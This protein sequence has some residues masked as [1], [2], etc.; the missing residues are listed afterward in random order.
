MMNNILKVYGEDLINAEVNKASVAAAGAVAVGSVMG[1]LCINV[2][3]KT[4]VVVAS[5]IT[6]AVKQADTENGSYADLL[7]ITVPVNS[8]KAGELLA[9][10]VLP[11][12][13]K[14][15]V[16]ATASSSTSNSGEVRVTLGYL[17]R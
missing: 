14:N 1:A 13:C 3:A 4:D 8:Y 5:A 6:I 9:T 16:S 2:F 10:A 11:Q 15:F 12:E 7:K 17:A